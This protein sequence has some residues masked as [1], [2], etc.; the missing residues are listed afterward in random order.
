MT[1]NMQISFLILFC[2]FMNKDKFMIF[3]NEI[4][5]QSVVH[6]QLKIAVKPRCE[7]YNPVL[8]VT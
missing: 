6:S 2:I 8:L 7:T 5:K 1:S 4:W 3:I